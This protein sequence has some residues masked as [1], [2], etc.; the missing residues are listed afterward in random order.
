MSR[1]KFIL[2]LDKEV[3]E[4]F[5][6]NLIELNTVKFAEFWMNEEPKGNGILGAFPWCH[7]KESH[8]YWSEINNKIKK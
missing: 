1:I 4:R 5:I 7:T 2:E 6:D 3:R 8:D